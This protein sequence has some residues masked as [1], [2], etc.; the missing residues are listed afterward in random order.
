MVIF[1]AVVVFVDLFAQ[2]ENSSCW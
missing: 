1:H 2:V